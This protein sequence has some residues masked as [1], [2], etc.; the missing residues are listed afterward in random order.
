MQGVTLRD[1]LQNMY[2]ENLYAFH[3]KPIQVLTEDGSV[4]DLV[5]IEHDPIAEVTFIKV[6][7]AG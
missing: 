3:S 2:D 7:L 1:M 6:E 5:D 4:Y